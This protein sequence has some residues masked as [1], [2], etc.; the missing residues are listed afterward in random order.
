MRE[1]FQK[2]EKEERE[3]ERE[4]GERASKQIEIQGF[5]QKKTGEE[6][7]RLSG[8]VVISLNINLRQ[9]D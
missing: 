3:R 6:D 7:R 8:G 1:I 2:V 4:K 9:L 5:P